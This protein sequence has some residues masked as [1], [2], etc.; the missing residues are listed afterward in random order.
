MKKE[1]YKQLDFEIL[2]PDE[3]FAAKYNVEKAIGLG[4]AYLNLF[5]PN[6]FTGKVPYESFSADI[7]QELKS[8]IDA[9][10]ENIDSGKLCSMDKELFM[11]CKLQRI[12]NDYLMKRETVEGKNALL[13]EKIKNQFNIKFPKQNYV[14]NEENQNNKKIEKELSPGELLQLIEVLRYLKDNDFTRKENGVEIVVTG[15]VD[16]LDINP[17][18]LQFF[19]NTNDPV[20][21]SVNLCMLYSRK[22]RIIAEFENEFRMGIFTALLNIFDEN[23]L[24]E[25]LLKPGFSAEDIKRLANNGKKKRRKRIGNL[26]ILQLRVSIKGIKPP[27]W[28]KILVSSDT[29]L[30]GL[31]LIIQA[32]FGWGSLSLYEFY[33]GIE[34]YS[35]PDEFGSKDVNPKKVKLTEFGMKVGDKL[36]YIYDFINYWEHTIIVQKILPY[37]S[38]VELPDCIAGKRNIPPE[39]CGG[40]VNYDKI[41]KKLKDPEDPEHAKI[42]EEYPYYDPDEFDLKTASEDVKNY[43]EIDEEL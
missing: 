30:H 21:I 1:A 31:H 29:T 39:D 22:K 2:L 26:N 43:K 18:P 25:D 27:I 38:S 13:I 6:P 17:L 14:V 40:V 32:A 11:A 9:Y 15:S 3:D 36:D 28:R 24:I 4:L 19:C 5:V 41:M 33:D 16:G 20:K 37:D 10:R 8:F 12:V 7:S 23:S 34:Y 42:V 35:I